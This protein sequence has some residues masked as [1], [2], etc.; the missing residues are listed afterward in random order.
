MGDDEKIAIARLSEKIDSMSKNQ[1]KQEAAN[2]AFQ[3][4]LDSRMS[5]IE[6]T[7]WISLGVCGAFEAFFRLFPYLHL[8]KP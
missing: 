5:R 1:D 7:F 2:L 3:E 4:K 8:V 6:R